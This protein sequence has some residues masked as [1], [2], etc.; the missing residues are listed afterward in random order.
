MNIKKNKLIAEV[1]KDWYF[2]DS[3]LLNSHAKNIITDNKDYESYISLKSALLSDLHEFYN[4]I[5]YTP[6]SSIPKSVRHLQESAVIDSKKSKSVSAKLLETA[7]FKR[8]LKSMVIN[9]FKKD[10]KR[11]LTMVSDRIINERFLKMTLDNMLIG[12][13]MIECKNKKAAVDFK[14]SILEQAYMTVRTEMIKIASKYN[15]ALKN[16]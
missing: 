15:P 5:D 16:K 2:I 13:P 7:T 1:L 14:G 11:D 8:Q 4:H 10:Q 6:T 3:A 9:E 12:K